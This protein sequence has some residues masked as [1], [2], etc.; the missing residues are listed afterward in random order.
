MVIRMNNKKLL[1]I[2]TLCILIIT[3]LLVFI[4]KNL[5]YFNIIEDRANMNTAFVL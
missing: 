1:N 4:S 5:E 3:P 2:I